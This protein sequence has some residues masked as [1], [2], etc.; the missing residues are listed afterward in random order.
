[1]RRREAAGPAVAPPDGCGGTGAVRV[2]RTLSL[3]RVAAD[4]RYGPGTFADRH[5][6]TASAV[7]RERPGESKRSPTA[8]AHS[9][10][11]RCGRWLT[12]D[13]VP[14]Q[15]SHRQT[16]RPGC[17]NRRRVGGDAPSQRWH[18]H[19]PVRL[20]LGASLV[21]SACLYGA[22]IGRDPGS[23]LH[24]RPRPPYEPNPCSLRKRGRS[25]PHFCSR[26]LRIGTRFPCLDE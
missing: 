25:A 8:E 23:T 19:L 12:A 13:V 14:S 26:S 9:T 11:V 2:I 10:V 22:S 5:T 24:R 3:L 7:R 21:G 4:G 17:A 6:R 15:V 16:I 1:M 18:H 20:P